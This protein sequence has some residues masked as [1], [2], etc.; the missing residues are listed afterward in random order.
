MPSSPGG[1]RWLAFSIFVLATAL[2]YLDRQ[3]LAALAP[4]IRAEFGIDNT[5]Y[6]LL[7]SAFSITYALSAPAAGLLIDRIGLNRGM[8]IAVALWSMVGVGTGFV[9]SFG[10]LL[11]LRGALGL[12]ESGG[13]PGSGKAIAMYLPPRERALGTAVNQIGLSV[14]AAGAPLMATWLALHYGWRSA[15]VVTG[16]LGFVWIPVWL[17]TS[18]RIPPAQPQSEGA[19]SSVRGMLA[20]RRLWALTAANVLSMTLYSLWLNWTTVFLVDAQGLSQAEA[21]SRFAWI[22]PVFANLGGLLGGWMAFRLIRR[23]GPVRGV[24]IRISRWSGALLLFTAAIPWMPSPALATA[25]I[26]WSFFWITAQSVNI[27]ALPLD[28]YGAR[29]AAFAVAALT[30][31]FGVMQTVVS[32]GIGRLLDHYGFAPV[33]AIGAALPLA[34]AG[35]LRFTEDRT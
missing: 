31:A 2:N 22:P 15:F 12:T 14:G 3:V 4:E 10:A 35:V 5:G 28:I 21:N 16:A 29:R 19:V 20:D 23:G 24:R 27:Y 26:C 34:A 33:C 8:S 9:G 17:W 25:G 13:I 30:F 11:F 1:L 7:L 32:P 18:R 6:G